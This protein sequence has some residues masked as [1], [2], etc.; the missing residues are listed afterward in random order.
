MV[1][2][3]RDVWI[4]LTIVT[5]LIA[6]FM[7]L[8][9]RT[10][11]GS[12]LVFAV[13]L[14]LVLVWSHRSRGD[15]LRD[16]GFRIDTAARTASLFAP[17]VIVVVAVT[18]AVGALLESWRFPAADGALDTLLAVAVFGLSQQYV[19]LGFYYRG[20]A[21]ILRSPVLAALLTALV[22]AGFHIPNPFLMCVTFAVAPIS[23]AVYR[24][25]PNLPVSGLAHGLIS[26]TLYYS[27]PLAITHNLRVGPSY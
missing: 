17:I 16:L 18:L 12:T 3:L 22:F 5:L 19:L 10:F 23:I 6:S 4:Q 9:R 1:H 24:R 27:L 2:A 15:S 14:G 13:V 21:S 26:F 20:F 11:P 8:W 7:W 25:S